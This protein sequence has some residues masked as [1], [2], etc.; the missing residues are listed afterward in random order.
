MVDEDRS[1]QE[2]DNR[3]ELERALALLKPAASRID[4]DSFLFLAGQAS[5]ERIRPGR[6]F[7]Q[8]MWPAATLVSTLTALVLFALLMTRP[9]AGGAVAESTSTKSRV[10][11]PH[12][13]D[14]RPGNKHAQAVAENA[15][16]VNS[17]EEPLP[18]LE[19]SLIPP[20]TSL[21]AEEIAAASNYP[22]L[23]SLV[24]A[25]GIDVLPEPTASSRPASDSASGE[26]RTEREL[27][28]RLSKTRG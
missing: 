11:K 1:N 10:A 26:P 2:I 6:A 8:W 14:S 25:Y 21:A 17:A 19:G 16:R 4:R 3:E 23:R 7:Q 9:Q 24:L 27:F 18:A 20:L 5:A 22:R 15:S 13:A 28:Q 12:P